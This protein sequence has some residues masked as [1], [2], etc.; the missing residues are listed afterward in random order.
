MVGDSQQSHDEQ[1]ILQR[2]RMSTGPFSSA[3]VNCNTTSSGGPQ[4]IS[5]SRLDVQNIVESPSER[6]VIVCTASWAGSNCS[7]MLDG[8]RFEAEYDGKRTMWITGKKGGNLGKRVVAKYRVLDRRSTA[9]LPGA[10]IVAAALKAANERHPDL[11]Q[12][13]QQMRQLADRLPHGKM[14]LDE[15]IEAL[16]TLAKSSTELKP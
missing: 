3:Q 7:P 9:E 14:S 12:Y 1:H 2:K 11:G 10:D 15:Y 13:D 16:Y 4:R 6:F 8:D 5:G